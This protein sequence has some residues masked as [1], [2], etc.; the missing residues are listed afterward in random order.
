M[1]R[2]APPTGASPPAVFGL[3]DGMLLDLGPLAAE[4]CRRYY[5][6]YP[7]DLERYGH[8]GRAWCDHDSRHLLSWALE[9]ARAGVVDCVEQ[10]LWLGRVLSARSFPRDRLVAHVEAIGTVIDEAGLGELGTRAAGRMR[11]AAAAL[12]P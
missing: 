11:E 3:P 6:R 8:A 5:Q 2:L 12:A 7:D 1:S 9:D 4:A 10:V